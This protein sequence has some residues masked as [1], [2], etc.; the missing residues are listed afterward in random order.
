MVVV[1]SE[2]PY[3]SNIYAVPLFFRKKNVFFSPSPRQVHGLP[4]IKP[5]YPCIA[6]LN[7]FISSQSPIT[8]QTSIEPIN[9][10]QNAFIHEKHYIGKDTAPPS[11]QLN[12]IKQIVLRKSHYFNKV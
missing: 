7:R 6:T 1:P 8:E 2:R 11:R 3:N 9:P 5:P 10:R 12:F 4:T